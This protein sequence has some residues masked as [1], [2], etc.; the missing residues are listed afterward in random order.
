M[1]SRPTDS[2]SLWVG[3][4]RGGGGHWR[5]CL[6]CSR[7]WAFW[8]W[9][10]VPVMVMIRSSEPSS[11]SSILMEAPDSSSSFVLA[12]VDLRTTYSA[13]PRASPHPPLGSGGGGRGRFLARLPPLP[14]PL[15]NGGGGGP[16][17]GLMRGHRPAASGGGRHV[18]EAPSN[19][20]GETPPSDW[21]PASLLENNGEATVVVRLV[22]EVR[23]LLNLGSFHPDDPPRQALVDQQAKLRVKICPTVMLVEV[24]EEVEVVVVVVVEEVGIGR[25]FQ[26]H[27]GARFMGG[28]NVSGWGMSIQYMD[29]GE[30]GWP[31]IKAKQ[32]KRTRSSTISSAL[33]ERLKTCSSPCRPLAVYLRGNTA[34][35]SLY[36]GK[37]I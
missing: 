4:G 3:G 10:C 12:P 28:A 5:T 11:G 8:I 17:R 29:N 9:S 34:Q 7:Y 27:L 24:E 37:N 19:P 32:K 16:R 33:R 2:S 23:V 35:L 30:E 14:P 15:F 22:V 20:H 31:K 21:S 13:A 26:S 6:F 18:I 1:Q 25:G 36:R